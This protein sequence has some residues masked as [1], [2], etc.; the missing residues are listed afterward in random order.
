MTNRDN[1]SEQFNKVKLLL[2]PCQD[3]SIIFHVNY[4]SSPRWQKN[5]KWKRKVSFSLL[6]HSVNTKFSWNLT[7]ISNL[8]ST[9]SLRSPITKHNNHRFVLLSVATS[10]LTRSKWTVQ[11]LFKESLEPA[12]SSACR[13][14][15]E[16]KKELS[17][18]RVSSH[19]WAVSSC[20]G[21]YFFMYVLYLP[22]SIIIHIR[23][24]L[25]TVRLKF[26]KHLLPECIAAS[27]T[28]LWFFFFKRLFFKW[29]AERH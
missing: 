24:L 15:Q 29:I 12:S 2:F 27:N 20:F 22:V 23:H 7:V 5:M 1:L 11:E 8:L 14:W 17:S 18:I 10:H 4:K 6:L 19:L 16:I 9:V 3:W 21:I 25:N 26:Q 28:S 13:L